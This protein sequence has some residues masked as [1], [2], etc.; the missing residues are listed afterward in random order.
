MG[1]QISVEAVVGQM[2][3]EQA[4]EGPAQPSAL[5]EGLRSLEC[6]Y[7][8]LAFPASKQWPLRAGLECLVHRARPLIRA[9]FPEERQEPG[10]EGGR[11]WSWG[12][13]GSLPWLQKEA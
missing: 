9:D 8:A 3:G 13:G 1:P 7:V 4:R 2:M 11:E 6:A 5:G 12:R 10:P